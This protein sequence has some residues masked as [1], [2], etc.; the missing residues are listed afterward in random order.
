MSA[1]VVEGRVYDQIS[2]VEAVDHDGADGVSRIC[3][4]KIITPDVPFEVDADGQ[5]RNAVLLLNTFLLNCNTLISK[6]VVTCIFYA[7]ATIG[8]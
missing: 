3:R 7:S 6:L 4:Y 5:W 2:H 1:D 8:Q